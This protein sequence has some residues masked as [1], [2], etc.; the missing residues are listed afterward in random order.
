[1]LAI[2]AGLINEL[3]IKIYRTF[4]GIAAALIGAPC[5]ATKSHQTTVTELDHN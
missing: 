4:S 2:D 3:F 5:R 1:M